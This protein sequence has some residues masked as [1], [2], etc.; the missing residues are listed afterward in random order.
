MQ[1][2]ITRGIA[3][4]AEG[5][6][7]DGVDPR[8]LNWYV[9]GRA[10]AIRTATIKIGSQQQSAPVPPDARGAAFTLDLPAGRAALRATFTDDQARE[11]GAFYVYVRR[12]E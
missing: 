2:E 5:P 12:L 9:G 6:L 1:A 10:M 7:G 11:F 8:A 4:D 3:D